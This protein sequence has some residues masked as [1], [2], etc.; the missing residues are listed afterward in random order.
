VIWVGREEEIFLKMGLD[1]KI[2]AL[3][4]CPTGCFQPALRLP[5]S[6]FSRKA[7]V[8]RNRKVS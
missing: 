5:T 7:D 1:A 6:G 4:I 8:C 3:L 2:K